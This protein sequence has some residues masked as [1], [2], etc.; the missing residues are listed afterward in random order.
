[1]RQANGLRL[2]ALGHQQSD[3][4][5]F[6]VFVVRGVLLH[7]PYE[8]QGRFDMP[9]IDGEVEQFWM[10]FRDVTGECKCRFQRIGGT[11]SMGG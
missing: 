3:F 8:T 11:T 4:S 5:S 9:I 10:E 6:Q 2:V 1:M 7:E